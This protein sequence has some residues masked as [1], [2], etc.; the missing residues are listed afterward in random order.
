MKVSKLLFFII[1]VG[2]VLA[3]YG[4]E[5]NFEHRTLKK[6]LKKAWEVDLSA[7]VEMPHLSAQSMNTG[8]F[9]KAIDQNKVMGYVYVGRIY[10]CRAGG[11]SINS[12]AASGKSEYF[13]AFFIYDTAKTIQKVRVFNYQATHGHEV[14]SRGWLKQFIG[15]NADKPLKVG[16]SV[17]TISGATISVHAI[18]DEV[19]YITG[20][21]KSENTNIVIGDNL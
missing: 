18:T 6:E 10:S 21:L 2:I 12:S 1:F 19:N 3:V 11:C 4:A 15:F 5:V 8:K 17:D 7:L 20:L 9:F 13:D 14:C 16:K